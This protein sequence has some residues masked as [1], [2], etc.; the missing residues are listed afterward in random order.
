M[1][2]KKNIHGDAALSDNELIS[3]IR[4][5]DEKA[6]NLLIARHKNTVSLLAKKYF[7]SSLTDDDWFQEGMIGLIYAVRTFDCKKNAS[8]STYACVCIK[9]RLNSTLK[10][11][12][13]SGNTPLNSSLAYNDDIVPAALSTEDNYINNESNLFFTADFINK[14]SKTEQA[15]IKCYLSGFSYC[16][17]AEKL[18]ITEKAVDNALY[19]AK[20]KLK[21]SVSE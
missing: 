5:G 10:K 20:S 19:R 16:E 14:L 1:T 11:A 21:K 15:V 8:F 12:N 9:N 2:E 17:T 13:N 7:S 4:I 18:G 6:F 3:L